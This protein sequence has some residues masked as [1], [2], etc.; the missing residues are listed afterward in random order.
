MQVQQELRDA[1]HE[2]NSS[3]NLLHAQDAPAEF[4][5][6]VQHTSAR[7]A[8]HSRSALEQKPTAGVRGPAVM[9]GARHHP[10]THQQHPSAGT[11]RPA[12]GAGPGRQS[13]RQRPTMHPRNLYAQQEP[14]F[15]A[16]STA[17]PALAPYVTIG[18]SGRGAV[19]FSDPSGFQGRVR[20]AEES[21]CRQPL[22]L[23]FELIS[24]VPYSRG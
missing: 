17:Y 14:D 16:L 8:V 11:K 13:K 6:S 15:A 10:P 22:L 21:A 9:A 24:S 23:G 2:T 1:I 5:D 12:E 19:N 4:A 7:S 18:T 20:N 3:L